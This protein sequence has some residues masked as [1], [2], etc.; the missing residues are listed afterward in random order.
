MSLRNSNVSIKGKYFE[1]CVKQ[2]LKY[3]NFNYLPQVSIDK[4][5]GKLLPGKKQPILD[6]VIAPK[7]LK[8]IG[9]NVSECI[10]LSCKYTCRERWKQDDFLVNLSPLKYLLLV[11]TNDYP[12]DFNTTPKRKIITLQRKENDTETI[13]FN[14]F[15][16]ELKE[17]RENIPNKILSNSI[18]NHK[19][20]YCDLCCGMG[21]FHYSFNK[22]LP[23]NSECVLACDIDKYS[24]IFY[25]QNYNI[26]ILDDVSKINFT[27]INA[28][29]IFSGNLCQSFSQ[30]GKRKGL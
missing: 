23:N 5:T 28:D 10:V 13:T 8:I 1:K 30:I 18:E 26:D 12:K 17:F 14:N 4:N 16:N 2:I 25:K 22:V 20:K 7:N 3:Y 9:T 29:I 15:L 27:K 11:G 19:I 24:K 6:F 21:S